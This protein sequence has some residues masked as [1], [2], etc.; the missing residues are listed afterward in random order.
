MNPSGCDPVVL[1]VVGQC[2]HQNSLGLGNFYSIF[3]PEHN[4]LITDTPFLPVPQ[5][6]T[7]QLSCPILV[8]ASPVFGVGDARS[9]PIASARRRQQGRLGTRALMVY[10]AALCFVLI[11]FSWGVGWLWSLRDVPALVCVPIWQF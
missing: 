5:A 8:S 2:C 3:C 1:A 7:K 11:C 9:V 4:L 6:H 10:A